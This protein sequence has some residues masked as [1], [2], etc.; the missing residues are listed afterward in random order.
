MKKH[1]RKYLK[2]YLKKIL[3]LSRIYDG[4]KASKYFNRKYFE[5][6]KWMFTSREDTNYT[7]ELTDKNKLELLCTIQ[8]VTEI[9]IHTLKNI[10]MKLAAI[11]NS[12][13]F[14]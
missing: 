13:N 5:I 6:F 7:Y 8:V 2:K 4:Y 3:I 9:E 1:L 11:M 14:S 10:L 12:R